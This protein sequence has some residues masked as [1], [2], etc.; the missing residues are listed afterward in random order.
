[1][2]PG[3]VC[4]IGGDIPGITKTHI[5]NAF[6]ALGSGDAVFGPAPDGGFWLVGLR[7]LASPPSSLFKGVR[8]SSEHALHDTLQSVSG[9]RV[10]LTDVLQDV[11]T[12]ADLERA[13]W[14]VP[15]STPCDEG[16]SP[17]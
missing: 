13:N 4:I 9:M 15:S 7:R 2:P 11:D 14:V 6:R 10:V 17:T 3:P 16:L 5:T 1:M 12:V 8:W